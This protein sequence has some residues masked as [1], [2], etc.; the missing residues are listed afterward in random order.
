MWRW[1]IASDLVYG[2]GRGVAVGEESFELMAR[3]E[4]ARFGGFKQEE[5]G[6]RRAASSPRVLWPTLVSAS[7]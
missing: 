3:A 1:R 2:G 4:L 6:E 7:F 5:S